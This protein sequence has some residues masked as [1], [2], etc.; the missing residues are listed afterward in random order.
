MTALR[1]PRLALLLALPFAVA[2]AACARDQPMA[3]GKP[4]DH[5]A[6]E[7]TQASLLPFWSSF[8][9][10]RRRMAFR[11]LAEIGEPA[12]PTLVDLL[13]HGRSSVRAD[14]F[15]TLAAL[16]PRAAGA[17]PAL[18]RMLEQ[19][20]PAR[21]YTA[22]AL[23]GAIGPSAVPA[24]PRLEQLLRDDD[25]SVREAAARALAAMGA[26]G[27]GALAR[28]HVTADA[29]TR[30]ASIRALA[31][32]ALAP[33]ARRAQLVSAL[34][35]TS[36]VVR[37]AAVDVL[38]DLSSAEAESLAVQ[39]ARATNDADE[40]VA[41]RARRAVVG[42]MQRGRSTP[43]FL[44]VLVAEADP[45]SR[46]SAAWRLGYT[47][48]GRRVPGA[49]RHAP[50]VTA[51]LVDALDDADPRVRVHAGRALV[52]GGGDAGERGAQQLRRDIAVVAPVLR[53]RAAQALWEARR[54]T[55]VV[56]PAY[57]SGLA[58]PDPW[59][60]VETISA[61]VALG[62]RART[63]APEL[64]RLAADPHHEVRE[65]AARVLATIA[66]EERARKQ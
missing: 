54:D 10:D 40:R 58:D 65:R 4:L 62:D 66:H 15:G 36:A 56:R 46:A 1:L 45:D 59:T 7:A 19:G 6:D 28:A 41:A 14:A 24:V 48:P 23:L 8:A 27:A 50:A 63:F 53:V 43:S 9:D 44:A 25:V 12:V 51:A 37:L 31:T 42:R 64:A 60:R 2:L 11:R 22:A 47:G 39:L 13:G 38:D 34:A 49:I 35:D 18:L 20:D 16:G 33:E 5:W 57:Q 17:V 21:R 30:A 32:T 61:I 52:H 29:P 26:A 55:T 3:G